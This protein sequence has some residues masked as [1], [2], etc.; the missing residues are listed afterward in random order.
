MDGAKDEITSHGADSLQW[1][2][3]D[4]RPRR[5]TSDLTSDG[6][7]ACPRMAMSDHR[8]IDRCPDMIGHRSFARADRS[9]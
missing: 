5:A 4:D 2:C 1:R 8:L 9:P 6:G 7:M 3:R